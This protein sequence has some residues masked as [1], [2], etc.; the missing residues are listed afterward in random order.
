MFLNA[1]TI[2]TK[3]WILALATLFGFLAN[4]ILVWFLLTGTERNLLVAGSVLGMVF[5]F[6]FTRIMTLSISKSIDNLSSITLLYLISSATLF[7]QVLL[8]Y[9]RIMDGKMTG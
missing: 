3:G 4:T 9:I 6:I 2:K 8:Y 5:F 7:N 1:I